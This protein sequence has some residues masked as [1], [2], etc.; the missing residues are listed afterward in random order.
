MVSR[1][2][3]D[4]RGAWSAPGTASLARL[5]GSRRRRRRPVALSH[6]LRS[7]L[8]AMGM[9]MMAS[10]TATDP[11]GSM[12]I[13]PGFG[14]SAFHDV[15]AQRPSVPIAVNAVR[16]SGQKILVPVEDP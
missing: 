9:G 12:N 1:R 15:P 11:G 14:D 13:V 7:Y 2:G 5:S 8:A 6:A 10:T 4:L 3:C 16:I